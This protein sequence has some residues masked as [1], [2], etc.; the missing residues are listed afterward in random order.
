MVTDTMRF[1]SFEPEVA[2]GIGPNTD[3]DR[4]VWPPTIHKLHYVFDGWLGDAIL[5]SFPCF[6]VTQDAAEALIRANVRGFQL[7]EVKISVSDQFRDLY[8]SRELPHFRWLKI[9]GE[10]GVDDFG[11]GADHRL[12]ISERA[13]DNLSSFGIG[14]AVA[15]VVEGHAQ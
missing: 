2:G 6:I 7:D 15:K 11:I 8:P 10:A 12:V 5:E 9:V 14:R 13:M 1:F 4:S 3:L